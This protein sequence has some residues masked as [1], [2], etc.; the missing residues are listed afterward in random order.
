MVQEYNAARQHAD[1]TGHETQ[2]HRY[3]EQRPQNRN[4]QPR[5]VC[6]FAPDGKV[7]HYPASSDDKESESTDQED[8]W[9][10]TQTHDRDCIR[11]D[12]SGF[13][14]IRS[15]IVTQYVRGIPS[16]MGRGCLWQISEQPTNQ[17]LGNSNGS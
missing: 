1:R 4:A 6:E 10:R 15:E 13:R 11:R 7:Q 2:E 12:S 3:I 9:S 16:P 17:P 14:T 5:S 8:G